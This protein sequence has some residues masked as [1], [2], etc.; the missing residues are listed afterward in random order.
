MGSRHFRLGEVAGCS[1]HGVYWGETYGR[2]SPAFFDC[3]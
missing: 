3:A 1:E 2:V